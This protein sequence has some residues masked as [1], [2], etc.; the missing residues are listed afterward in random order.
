MRIVH[1]LRSPV[2]GLFRHVADVVRGQSA[3]GHDVGLVCDSL[4]GGE[5]AEKVLDGLS[6]HLPLGLSRIPMAR[7]IGIGD[8]AATR[9]VA[10]AVAQA[11]PDIVHGHGAKGAAY[12][13]LAVAAG[14]P[15]RVFTPH[16]GSL[17]FEPGTAMGR[18]Y[19][20]L[21]KLLNRR[22]DLFLFE[23]AFIERLY[24]A[25]VG[26]PSATAR[27]VP[28][29]VGAEEFAAVAPYPDATDL[30]YIGE[31]RTLKGVD[32]L[33]GAMTKLRERGL[34]LTAT[35]VGAGTARDDLG[36]QAEQAGLAGAVR[37]LPPMPARQAFALG[38]IMA[39]PSRAESF[40]YIVME[41][42]A[43]GKP[44]IA[45]RVGGI[46]DMFGPLA[47]R[48][49]RP[50]DCDAFERAL[51]H[52]VNDPE[53]IAATAGLLRERIRTTFSLDDMVEGGLEAYRVALAA[54]KS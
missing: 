33:L 24:R 31:L 40:P 12:T 29:G 49:V 27:I 21:E 17:L 4:T 54:R 42:A 36:R 43:A 23:S 14:G 53:R 44:L 1:V 18:F 20:T 32:I 28:N 39:V 48:L 7:H 5:H 26:E 25:K 41:A 22:T 34:S 38:R 15:L 8:L 13:R 3:R 16:G 51:H 19:L 45:T 11:A 2:G 50:D 9:H 46:P 47:D 52:A 37:F 10:R 30:L 35:I 6:E